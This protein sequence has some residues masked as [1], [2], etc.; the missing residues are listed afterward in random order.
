MANNTEIAKAEVIIDG[1]EA[2]WEI[3]NLKKQTKELKAEMDKAFKGGDKET[4]KKLKGEID[5]V[6]GSM[7][8]VQANVV[9][10][11]KVLKNLNGTNLADLKK[12]QTQITA[13]LSKME[14][15]T[16]A[17]IDKSKQLQLVE[18][19]LKKV[20]VEMYGVST[21]GGSMWS[22]M[23]DGFNRFGGIFAAVSASLVG[24]VFGFKKLVEAADEY[25]KKVAML[26]SLTGLQGENLQ[27]LSDEAKK[28]SISTDANGVRITKSAGDIV[29]AFTKMG[30][31]KPE[32]LKNKEALAA[33]TK[34]ALTL[35]LAAGMETVPAV[36]GLANTMNQFNA[37]AS[38]AGRF[39]NVLAAGSK[40]GAAE[41]EDISAAIIKCGS[42]ANQF[43]V[44]IEQSVGM[45]EA[46]SEK[47]IKG[48]VAGT[49]LRNVLLKLATSGDDTLNPSLVGIGT[50][51]ENLKAK[52]LSATEMTKLFGLENYTVANILMNNKERV[53]E[54][55]KAVTGTK[56]AYE[57]A[58]INTSTNAAKLDQAKN[59]AA[60]MAIE[61]G[62][63]LAPALTFSTNA[64]SY[65]LKGIMAVIN[66]Y[67]EHS[68]LINAAII[69]IVAM[70]IA[71]NAQSI[72]FRIAR[73]FVIAYDA[74]MN[75]VRNI[76]PWKLLTG[77][78]IGA[79]IAIAA[80]ISKLSG[81]TQEQK[82][83]AD[84][85][86]EIHK[87]M[88][89]EQIDLDM[90]MKRIEQT[91]IGTK[92]RSELIKELNEKYGTYLGYIISETASNEQLTS[93]LKKVNE[94]IYKKIQ[95]EVH[96]E[97]LKE[98]AG[99]INKLTERRAELEAKINDPQKEYQKVFNQVQIKK[100]EEA[101]VQ[102]EIEKGKYMQKNLDILTK[103]NI[104]MDLAYKKA[105]DL[106][107]IL[108]PEKNT[109]KIPYING[110]ANSGSIPQENQIEQTKSGGTGKSKKQQEKEDLDKYLA[111]LIA[112]Q[113]KNAQELHQEMLNAN[114]REIQI[115]RDK[116]AK[117]LETHKINQ[118]LIDAIY[119]KTSSERTAIETAQLELW[120]VIQERLLKEI[121][122]KR[123][124]QEKK[125]QDNLYNLKKNAGLLTDKEI[126][127]HDLA[128][129]TDQ[130]NKKLIDEEEFLIRKMQLIK[131]YD[132]AEL[133]KGEET[134]KLL[135]DFKDKYGYNAPKKEGVEGVK[136]AISGLDK[137]KHDELQ[138][139]EKDA[140][141][142]GITDTSEQRFNIEKK[143]A[144][145][146]VEYE[147]K[148]IEEKLKV[149]QK[150]VQEFQAIIE[151]ASNMIAAAKEGEALEIDAINNREAKEY[152][153]KLKKDLTAFNKA[154]ATE[155]AAAKG[156]KDKI[157]AI[158]KKYADKKAKMDEA[159]QAKKEALDAAAEE[160]KKQLQ[161]QYAEI[162]FKVTVAKIIASTALSIMQ[163]F[164]QL[165][166]IAGAIA[167][168]LIGATGAIQISNAMKQ[169]DA[170]MNLDSGGYTTVTGANDGRQY[171]AKFMGP[172]KTGLYTN[173]SLFLAAENKPEYVI[174][175]NTMKNPQVLNWVSAIENIK[176]N[177]VP[178]Y[179]TGGFTQDV[180]QSG[181][182][183]TSDP[184]FQMILNSIINL[185]SS[186]AIL[187]NKLGIPFRGFILYDDIQEADE[188]V[189]KIIDESKFTR[190]S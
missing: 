165:G 86:E 189:N 75:I 51:L 133:K 18:A 83:F 13:E 172:A 69:G 19:E 15:G 152:D 78:V 130:L 22:R 149:A 26:S 163:G 55:T 21:A 6:N 92:E 27:W 122:D 113:K 170:V 146:G 121:Y 118:A 43:N 116:Y 68:R 150:Y 35:A 104:D 180:K 93:S 34:E 141:I 123:E 117:E 31:A 135:K 107:N 186:V 110:G 20:K 125:Y 66:V 136:E 58:N 157:E 176:S 4:W 185:N 187:N 143:Y 148:L 65:L 30:S 79:G 73:Q 101:L 132:E 112:A 41:V 140:L 188:T 76:N 137:K 70:T 171:N 190:S 49:G 48:E 37:P 94:E 47:G 8:K 169:R 85:Q 164:A 50:A 158:E 174:D 155:I 156:D 103:S 9:D 10:V 17:Y 175:Y 77:V 61:L 129:L 127:E 115:I 56:V 131:I 159:N 90:Y 24:V 124:E 145:M 160:R 111:D 23:A 106:K 60:L 40:E 147:K 1:K 184:I 153:A 87:K 89:Q 44:S 154:K 7:K 182:F 63:K 183:N 128:S 109:T 67:K 166:P 32:L 74:V 105:N 138:Q 59:K 134:Q 98:I 39:I 28:M 5:D 36:E 88:A 53:N 168:V 25:E 119:L 108:N 95:M 178:Q 97:K 177:R 82:R 84:A 81:A 161:K 38:E 102:L 54:L 120:K 162:E 33:V 57:Q 62:E 167:A 29:D 46:L 179:E 42:A 144:D 151:A 45:I 80:Y 100:I 181:N 72:A 3:E 52:N 12:A 96:G 91:K 14:R 139:M 126:Y 173:P 99:E 2:A 142:A 16:H 64:F 11:A 71:I 114:E